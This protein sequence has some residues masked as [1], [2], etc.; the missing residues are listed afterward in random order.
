MARN[1]QFVKNEIYHVYNRGVDRRVIFHQDDDR[2]RFMHDLFEF[3]DEDDNPNLTQRNKKNVNILNTTVSET[4]DNDARKTRKPIHHKARKPLV[5]ILAF[6]LMPNHF[7]LLLR[8]YAERGVPRFMHKLGTGYT[9]YFN[10]KYK[11]SGCLFQGNFK[12]VLIAN[13]SQLLHI[14][15][16]IHANP[17][18]LNN[19]KMSPQKFL[20]S[21]RWSSHIDYCGWKNF[22]SIT[23]RKFLLELFDGEENYRRSFNAW[24][25]N[26][27]QNIKLISNIAIE[28][29][30]I[31]FISAIAFAQP[32]CDALTYLS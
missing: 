18:D 5:E 29:C 28:T 2:V 31:I 10:G 21:Y 20:K 7:H 25:K 15:Y 30:V 22:P 12:A 27:E 24:L 26:K 11:R 16:Y 8:Q 3:N 6:T 4:R 1:I 32:L 19:G 17:L 13:Q 14:P 23:Q 9:N